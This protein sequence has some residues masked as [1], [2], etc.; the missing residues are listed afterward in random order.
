MLNIVSQ[1][2]IDLLWNLVFG[3]PF[4]IKQL[5]ILYEKMVFVKSPYLNLPL[6]KKCWIV[7]LNN[8]MTPLFSNHYRSFYRRGL[9]LFW[10]RVS[11]GLRRIVLIE[12]R[13]C[14]QLAEEKHLTEICGIDRI[15]PKQIVRG[16]YSDHY[17]GHS[18]FVGARNW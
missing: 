18:G 14:L 4:R 17:I 12:K 3:I 11:L 1:S 10:Y 2:D 15:W 7:Q 13:H 9:L 8:K 16:N 5:I 6:S